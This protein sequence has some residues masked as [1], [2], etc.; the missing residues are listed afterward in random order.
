MHAPPPPHA[1]RDLEK[2]QKATAAK[3]QSDMDRAAAELARERFS[4][5]G[6]GRP[7]SASFGSRER[8]LPCRVAALGSCYRVVLE[9]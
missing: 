2:K 9:S 8:P 6:A 4:A 7:A 3:Q 5:E 1:A